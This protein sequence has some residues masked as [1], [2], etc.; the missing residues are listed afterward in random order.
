MFMYMTWR[1]MGII[2]AAIGSSLRR[3]LV[4]AYGNRRRVVP[5]AAGLAQ[6]VLHVL[7][8]PLP[9]PISLTSG[10]WKLNWG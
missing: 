1:R 9:A 3:H 4:S 8:R 5:R 2:L 6:P 7:Q 10:H